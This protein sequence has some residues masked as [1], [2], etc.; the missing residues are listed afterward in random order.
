MMESSD[1]NRPEGPSDRRPRPEPPI[2]FGASFVVTADVGRVVPVSPTP[3]PTGRDSAFSPI[4]P[5]P[6]SPPPAAPGTVG[7][8][9]PFELKALRIVETGWGAGWRLREAPPRRPWMDEHTH[10]YHCLPLVVANQWGWEVLCPTDVRVT[11]D[12]S[13]DL[14]GLVVEVAPQFPPAVKSQFGRGILTFSPPWLFRT[15]PGWDLLAKGPANRWKENCVPLEGIIETWWL[16]YTF[17]FN[18][19]L[20][21]P[22]SVSFEEGEP[23]GQLVPIPHPTFAGAKAE[24]VPLETEPELAYQLSCWRDERR[25]RAGQRNQNHLMY[26]K[27]QDVRGHLVRVPVPPIGPRDGSEGKEQADPPGRS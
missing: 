2:D 1:P 5:V 7:E 6:V 16:P 21:A 14:T 20:V 8:L 11:W 10:A 4:S 13:P 27:A 18:W 26:R 12:G 17:T 24:E 19:K 22:G 3:V 23:L 9:P 15:P 25:R